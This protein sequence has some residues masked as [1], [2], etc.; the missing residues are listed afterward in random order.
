VR[1]NVRRGVLRRLPLVLAA[2]LLGCPQLLDDRFDTL[3]LPDA[4]GVACTGSRCGPNQTVDPPPVVDPP[5]EGDAGAGGVPG[6]PDASVD[7][8]EPPIVDEPDAAGP[9]QQT[10]ACWTLELTNSE[11]TA[12]SNCLGIR[13][14]NQ[15]TNDPFSAVV[16]SFQNGDACFDGSVVDDTDAWGAVYN[17]Q[18]APDDNSWNAAARAVNGFALEMSGT[19]LPPSLQVKY[20]DGS[21]DFCTT[22][23]TGGT[24]EVPF[25]ETH[26][27]CSTSS[28][29]VPNSTTLNML[30]VV[31]PVPADGSYPVDFCLQ[32]RALP[33]D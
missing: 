14:W 17:M 21:T 32:I 10:P 30:R 2:G 28:T 25:S 12:D 11:D 5:P 9:T 8:S 33:A 7:A 23:A 16:L 22:I 20:H 4:G 31:F 3:A 6:E 18:L 27:G 1:L 15:V 13:G 24:V 29:S 19:S 26:P